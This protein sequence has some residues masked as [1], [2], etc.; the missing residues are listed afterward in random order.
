VSRKR[1]TLNQAVIDQAA[2]I[3]NQVVSDILG[4]L[5]R[6]QG[7][8][9]EAVAGAGKSH[10]MATT[11][12]RL[13][14]AGARVAVAAPTNEQVYSLVDRIARLNPQLPV[15]FLP[16]GGR[17]LPAATVALPNVS[18]EATKEAV[19]RRTPL[20]VATL[21]KFAD[22]ATRDLGGYDA[23]LID[24]AFQADAAK[25]YAAGGIAT[26]HLLVG[27]S[28]Q[29][30]PFTT[31]PDATWWRGGPEDPLQTAVGVLL[32]NHPATPVHRLPITWR[33]DP[34][35]VA[36]ARAF[37]RADHHFDAAVLPEVRQLRLDPAQGRR[38]AAVDR[39][40]DEAAASG[41]AH[42]TLP[43]SALVSADPDT[44]RL[45]VD[46]IERLFGRS[47]TTEC[48]DRSTPVALDP[49]RVAVG[50]SHNDQKDLLRA[51]LD[52]AGWHD[53]VVS[54]ANKLQGLQYDVVI[55]WHPL[56]GQAEADAFHLDPGRLCVLL[57]RHRHACIVVG[58]EADRDLLDGMPPATPAYLGWN[59]DPVLDGWDIHE[60]V[61]DQLEKHHIAA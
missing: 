45:I 9:A 29:L 4:R 2:D 55:A 11:T 56:A 57:T 12:G 22:A 36:M 41:W 13:R 24:E 28:G 49:R 14:Q 47:P 38:T 31:L 25:Y 32:R 23:L 16:G 54:T 30:D 46:L 6:E 51:T 33:L 8:V 39:A 43:G 15:V 5:R 17:V 7:V 59:P 26:T 48:E 61:F 37:Y 1:P 27:D 40:L 21:D 60:S 10:F 50:V 18:V 53:V 58:R 35:S 19:D 20:V 34:R 44:A 42:L 3:G 52:A